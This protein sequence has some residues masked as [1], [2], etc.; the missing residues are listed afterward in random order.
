MAQSTKIINTNDEIYFLSPEEWLKA[1]NQLN[2]SEIKVLFYLRTLNPSGTIQS[3]T[4]TEIGKEL[5]LHKGT[6]SRALKSLKLK[7]WIEF[8]IKSITNIK[9]VP[10]SACDVVKLNWRKNTK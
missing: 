9:A 7:G 2:Y 10:N 6:V 4:V 3:V 8:E 1:C 5:N